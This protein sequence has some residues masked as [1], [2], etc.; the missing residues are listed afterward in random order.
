VWITKGVCKELKPLPPASFG[1]QDCVWSRRNQALVQNKDS[2]EQRPFLCFYSSTRR[3][4]LQ[5]APATQFARRS[6]AG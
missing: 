2:A 3:S 4:P 1:S 5:P 6:D